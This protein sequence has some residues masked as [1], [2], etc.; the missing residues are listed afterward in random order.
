MRLRI[1]HIVFAMLVLSIFVSGDLCAANGANPVV[2]DGDRL[3]VQAEGMALGELL[4]AV[5]EKTGVQ[6]R[7]DELVATKEVFLDFEGLP[8]SEG[9]KK[10]I[11]PLSWAAIYD[12]TGRLRRVFILERW[13]GSG[14]TEPREERDGSAQAPRVGLTDSIAFPPKRDSNSSGESKASPPGKGPVYSGDSPVDKSQ[15]EDGSPNKQDEIP[16]DLPVPIVAGSIH[17]PIPDSKGA[18]VEIPPVGKEDSGGTPPDSQA[19]IPENLPIPGTASSDHLPIP[20][21]GGL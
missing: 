3:S 19:E 11:H 13:K 5:E 15:S 1:K 14:M 2:I 4:I 12:D 21:S 8:L 17:V 20:G 18:P 9:I 7:F 16:E 6:F 10:I